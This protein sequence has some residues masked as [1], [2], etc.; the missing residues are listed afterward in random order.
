MTILEK[1]AEHASER[2]ET[3]KQKISSDEMKERALSLK[4]G[5]FEFD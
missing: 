4:T 1:L 3:A 2:V 5:E